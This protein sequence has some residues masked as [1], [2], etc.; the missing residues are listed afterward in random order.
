[1]AW[2]VVIS[3][4]S[5]YGVH[6]GISKRPQA[7]SQSIA[8]GIDSHGCCVSLILP[9]SPTEAFAGPTLTHSCS[10]TCFAAFRA[11]N[12]QFNISS[13]FNSL[14]KRSYL[15]CLRSFRSGDEDDGG[16]SSASFH[17]FLNS[18]AIDRYSRTCPLP[19]MLCSGFVDL[20]QCLQDILM[21][22]VCHS[23]ED[24]TI[25]KDL[26]AA[27]QASI[28]F[29]DLECSRRGDHDGED[30]QEMDDSALQ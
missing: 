3:E 21:I 5:I 18:F 29:I 17:L 30:C 9:L 20:V 26:V 12:K 6:E 8:S 14:N 11:N 13:N 28:F 16:R 22:T 10:A 27:C 24:M 15:L 2:N 19:K 23:V 1:M 7:Q 4:H 25:T